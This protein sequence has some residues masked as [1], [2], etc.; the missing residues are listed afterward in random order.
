VQQAA[1]L[2]GL[3]FDRVSPFKSGLHAPGIVVGWGQI[4]D[5]LRVQLIIAIINEVA[6]LDFEVTE[7]EVVLE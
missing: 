2:D 5:A 6:D 4:A 1:M 3:S 7:Q